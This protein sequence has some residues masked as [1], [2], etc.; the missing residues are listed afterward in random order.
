MPGY[1]HQAPDEGL[2][3]VRLKD[4]AVLVIDELGEVAAS[5]FK[6]KITAP[7][8]RTARI[9]K[10]ARKAGVPVIFANDAHIPGLD[11]ELE[12]WGPHNLAGA[13]ESQPSSELD[14][15]EGD[16]VVEKRRYSAFFQ[17]SL[18]LLL[19]ELGVNT[20]ILCG[21]DTNI[22]VMHTAADAYFNNYRIIVVTDA[23]ETFLIGDQQTGLDYMQRCYAATLMDAD[24]VLGLL[25]SG[26]GHVQ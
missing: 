25:S 4:C 20:L 12:L 18:R 8:E 6:D 17:T 13:P 1:A 2:E 7:T 14:Y 23:T 22:C 9:C 24:E 10:A 11:R 16:F 5:P 21:F 3:G 19:D 15:Q 26:E